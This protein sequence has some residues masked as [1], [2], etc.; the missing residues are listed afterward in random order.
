MEYRNITSQLIDKPVILISSMTETILSLWD[1]DSFEAR[2]SL[3]SLKLEE[4]LN[5][6]KLTVADPQVDPQ[7]GE[8]VIYGKYDDGTRN[9][10]GS[11]DDSQIVKGM[12]YRLTD[13]DR[14]VIYDVD[15]ESGQCLIM[16]KKNGKFL[17][18]DISESMDPDKDAF[19]IFADKEEPDDSC[20]FH[21]INC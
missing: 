13:A 2:E 3:I 21:F 9:Y 18:V 6:L 10:L 17:S 11:P 7:K 19:R 4:L 16:S 12:A 20:L 15:R 14:Y 5:P 1:D 8:C